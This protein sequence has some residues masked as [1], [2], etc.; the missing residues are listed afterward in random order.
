[1]GSV[2]FFRGLVLILLVLALVIAYQVIKP[3]LMAYFVKLEIDGK[4]VEKQTRE[5]EEKAKNDL[6]AVQ[7]VKT[8][9]EVK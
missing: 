2:L 9:N 1:M 4:K 6:E 8:E 7:D 3:W 5:E